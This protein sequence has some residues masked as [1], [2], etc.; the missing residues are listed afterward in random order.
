MVLWVRIPS[1]RDELQLSRMWPVTPLCRTPGSVKG[2][3]QRMKDEPEGQPDW[4][5]DGLASRYRAPDP[6]FDPR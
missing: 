2:G 4:T 1:D 6:A 5:N 3:A